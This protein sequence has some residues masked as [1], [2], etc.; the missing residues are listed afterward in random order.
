MRLRIYQDRYL[1]HPD[2]DTSTS[3]TTIS[4]HEAY[5]SGLEPQEL[6]SIFPILQIA[7]S[8]AHGQTLT[9]QD[10]LDLHQFMDEDVY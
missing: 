1:A 9:N 4:G 10:G 8:R 5:Q 7:R 2:H 3:Y 6:V